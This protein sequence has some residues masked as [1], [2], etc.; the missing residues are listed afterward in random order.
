MQFIS[1]SRLGFHTS[2]AYSRRGRTRARYSCRMTEGSVTFVAKFRYKRPNLF[3][4]LLHQISLTCGDQ[5]RFEEISTPKYL[6]CLT[7]SKGWPFSIIVGQNWFLLCVSNMHLH[8][9]V[10]KDIRFSTDQRWIRFISSCSSWKQ[11]YVSMGLYTS[12]SSA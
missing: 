5:Q 1:L 12:K 3:I 11:E 9:A 2:A 4:A 8:F 7:F 6:Y 10:L